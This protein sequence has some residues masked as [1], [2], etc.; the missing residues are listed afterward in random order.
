MNPIQASDWLTVALQFAGLSLFSIGGAIALLPEMH[1]FFIDDYGWMTEKQFNSGLAL[2]QAS[3]GP[4]ALMLAMM[5]WYF[6]LNATAVGS[7]PYGLAILG[8]VMTISCALIPT[9]TLAYTA[10]SWVQKNSEK[11]FVIAFKQG[12]APVVIGTMMASSWIVSSHNANYE[13]YWPNWALTIA[14]ILLFSFTR[15][16][17]LV[18][19]LGGALVGATGVIK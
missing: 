5:G 4:N 7:S 18:L 9:C 11:I 8:F 6:G 17:I 10:T 19:L 3:P 2:A 15:A 16:H 14:T 12:M 13:I 1:R